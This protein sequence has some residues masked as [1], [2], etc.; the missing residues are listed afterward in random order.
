[1]MKAA[2][3]NDLMRLLLA[4]GRGQV[5]GKRITGLSLHDA[6]VEFDSEGLASMALCH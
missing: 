3:T 1:M 4:P 2:A 5:S 6:S